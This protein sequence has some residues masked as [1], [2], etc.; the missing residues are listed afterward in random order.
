MAW[1]GDDLGCSV[2]HSHTPEAH[3]SENTGTDIHRQLGLDD[4][5]SNS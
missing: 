3:V 5:T 2:G 1:K 4:L